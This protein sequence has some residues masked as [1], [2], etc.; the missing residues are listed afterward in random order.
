MIGRHDITFPSEMPPEAME[1][2]MRLLRASWSEAMVENAETGELLGLDSVLVTESPVE[3]LIYK[4]ATARD[5]WKTN[6]AIPENE[7]LM[8]HALRG[9]RS[10]TIVVDDP[11]AQEMSRIIHAIRDHVYQDIFWIRADAA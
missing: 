11:D 7:N 8:V 1:G 4:N 3:L 10:I 2:A 5:S 9:D 6:G